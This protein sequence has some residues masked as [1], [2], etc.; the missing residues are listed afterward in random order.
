MLGAAFTERPGPCVHPAPTPG[1]S[2]PATLAGTGGSAGGLTIGGAI[3]QR[4]ELFAAAHSSVGVS[5]MLRMEL[6]PNGPPNIAE[7]GTVTN[8]VH[9]KA[10]VAISP[11][12]WVPCATP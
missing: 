1:L 5:D 12:H 11:Y 7:F 2:S 8:P 6:T 4:P 3:T 9:F 10:M